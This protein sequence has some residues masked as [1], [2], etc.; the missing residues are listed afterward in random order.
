MS[1]LNESSD[2]KSVTIKRN[3]VDDKSNGSYGIRNEIIYNTE[4]LKSI[5]FDYNDAYILVRGDI[6]STAYNNLT[7]VA[8]KNCAP[9]TKCAPITKIDCVLT[10]DAKDSDLAMLMYNWKK[11]SSNYSDTTANLWFYSK[12]KAT[13]FDTDTA[14]TNAFKSLNYEAK[15]LENTVAD[16]KKSIP[17]YATIAVSLRYLH[18]FWRSREIPLINLKDELK[19]KCAKRRVLAATGVKNDGANSSNNIF[20]IKDTKLY[21]HVVTLSAKET[22][23]ISNRFSKGFEEQF[24]G[25][26]MKQ[27]VKINIQQINKDIF[28]NQTL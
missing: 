25:M 28:L 20:T 6:I 2:S 7:S 23:K 27:K 22:Q 19:R 14:N 15:L 26:K 16:G 12:D 4:I 5:L 13:N 9:F 17:K 8:F 11:Y 3:I 24:I 18:D 1:L 21:A 10:D